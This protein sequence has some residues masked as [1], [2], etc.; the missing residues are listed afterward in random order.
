MHSDASVL[1]M[2]LQGMYLFSCSDETS[3]WAKFRHW[4]RNNTTHEKKHQAK[5]RLQ[6]RWFNPKLAL[7][8]CTA[9]GAADRNESHPAS[10]KTSLQFSVHLYACVTIV[11]LR[12]TLLVYSLSRRVVDT[13][14]WWRQSRTDGTKTHRARRTSGSPM[15]GTTHSFV[16][17]APHARRWDRRVWRVI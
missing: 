8:L 17:P 2:K 14:L 11:C 12:H 10:C 13:C 1:D 6:L 15:R 7:V 3:E 9:R 4:Q 16:A 5:R